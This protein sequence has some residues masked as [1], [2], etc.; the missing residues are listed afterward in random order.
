[1]SAGAHHDRDRVV[2][3]DPLARLPRC[4]TSAPAPPARA[5]RCAR[6][7]VSPARA[8]R[9]H[10]DRA[11]LVERARRTRG[12]PA[13]FATGTDSPVRLLWSTSD[14]PAQHHAVD[15]DR[16][17]GLHDH[18]LAD[19]HR[20][21][22]DL[23]LA[24]AAPHQ[25]ARRAQLEQRVERAARAAHGVDLERVAEREQEHQHRGLE[26]VADH[27]RADR[28]E[29][30]EQVHVEAEPRERRAATS[31]ARTSRRA[32][33]ES[34]KAASCQRAAAR[35]RA[36]A[37]CRRPAAPG[38]APVSV[39]IARPFAKCS[40]SAGDM[41]GAPRLGAR[42]RAH[43]LGAVGRNVAAREPDAAAARR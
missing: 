18:A 28:G 13:R 3:P 33:A 26:D 19:L 39:A 1:M 6:A 29:D 40:C 20:L 12:R 37:P 11:L 43:Q 25:R 36:R 10:L 16:L 30:H 38:T 7:S 32:S 23:D 4:A 27:A 35:R 24:P 41:L 9:A 15:R 21:G 2:A 14:A 17:A 31:A 42:Q 22:V 8:G 34:T 5:P